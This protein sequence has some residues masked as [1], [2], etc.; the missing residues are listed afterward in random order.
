MRCSRLLGSSCALALA[1]GTVWAVDTPEVEPNDSKAAA[2]VVNLLN[3]GDSLS[4]NS[5]SATGVGLDYFRVNM[6]VQA[7][8]IY[9]NRLVITTTGTA[10]HTGTIR[11]LNQTSAP[12]DTQAGIPWDGVV[13]TAGTTDSTAQTTST[14]TTPPRYNQ[15]YSFGRPGSMFYRVTGTASTTANYVSTWEQV[16]VNPALIGVFAPGQISFNWN[17]QGHTTD[18]DMWV[19][20]SNFNPIQGYGND[21][22][23]AALGGA[24]IATTAT[25]SWLARDFAPGTYYLAVSNFNVV[26]D[27]TSPSDDNFRTGTIMDF[28]GI[29]LNNSTT[30][31]LNLAFTVTDST[32]LSVAVPTTKV[33]PFDVNWFVFNVIPE[34]ASMSLLALAAPALLRRRR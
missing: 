34:P 17:G 33:D 1:A 15:W 30:V 26:N 7:A 20:D 9:R 16:P 21:D 32:S 28:P 31:N 12:A 19:Y 4:G 14:A 2:T 13:G 10:G 23:S 3:P 29:A 27:Q 25:Q 18:T 6:P 11:G 8:G 22:S 24:P 5:T